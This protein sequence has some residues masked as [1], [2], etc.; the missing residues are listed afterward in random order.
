VHVLDV[1]LDGA[2]DLA[3]PMA[4]SMNWSGISA[5][6][7]IRA[8]AATLPEPGGGSFVVAVRPRGFETPKWTGL[9]ARFD[10]DGDLDILMTTTTVQRTYTGTI[11]RTTSEHSIHLKGTKSN[12]DAMARRA[13]FYEG[14]RIR[15]VRGAPATFSIGCVTF[16]RLA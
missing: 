14:K 4:T 16:A 7:R 13:H 15:M 2:L 10:R 6:T 5:A 8:T 3:G 9:A 11:K 12:C 1:D